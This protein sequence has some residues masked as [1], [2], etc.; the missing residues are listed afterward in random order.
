MDR[1]RVRH[2]SAFTMLGMSVV[3]LGWAIVSNWTQR[4][5][6]PVEASS[7]ARARPP[8][9]SVGD[10]LPPPLD[11]RSVKASLNLPTMKSR[12]PQPGNDLVAKP[13]TSADTSPR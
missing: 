5:T 12:G 9:S 8:A 3:L 10:T 1:R 4:E 7:S 11:S 13:L 2:I 6:S